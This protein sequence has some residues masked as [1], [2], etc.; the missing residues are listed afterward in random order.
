MGP[1]RCGKT[2]LVRCLNEDES[3]LKRTQDMIYGLRTIDVPGSYLEIPWMYKHLIAASQD[4]SHILMLLDQSSGREVYSPGFAKVFRCPVF[5]VITKCDLN[6]EQEDACVRQ[7]RRA[8]V[9][10][11]YYRIS[12]VDQTGIDLLKADLIQKEER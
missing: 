6:P 8:G 7:L 12:T 5:G 10:E 2:S 4:A 9:P 11:P 1:N 3:P